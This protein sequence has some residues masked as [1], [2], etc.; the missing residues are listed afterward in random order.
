MR[1][2]AR[3]QASCV[4]FGER[5]RHDGLHHGRLLERM[6][7]KTSIDKPKTN[8]PISGPYFLDG[9]HFRQF[10][11][12]VGLRRRGSAPC[13]RAVGRTIL[14][15]KCWPWHP[16]SHKIHAIWA[17]LWLGETRLGYEAPLSGRVAVV[18]AS[19]HFPQSTR[20]RKQVIDL[21]RIHAS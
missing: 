18:V 21:L 20:M 6:R 14:H 11:G 16:R 3:S 19:K 17:A 1:Q 8:A 2:W 13:A 10:K 9:C 4:G 5:E 7:K 12:E 15:E